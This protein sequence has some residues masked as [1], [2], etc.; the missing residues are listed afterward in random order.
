MFQFL[1]FGVSNCIRIPKS[2]AEGRVT[3]LNV[4]IVMAV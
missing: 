1:S 2:Q 4:M 3:S